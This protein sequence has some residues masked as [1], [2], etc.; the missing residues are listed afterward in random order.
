MVTFYLFKQILLIGKTFIY[1]KYY[2]Y[3]FSVR[4]VKFYFKIIIVGTA[5]TYIYFR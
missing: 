1:Y 2:H 3:K 4:N 5:E